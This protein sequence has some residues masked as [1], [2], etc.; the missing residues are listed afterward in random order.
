[1][2]S[3][4]TENGGKPQFLADRET[5]TLFGRGRL[6]GYTRHARIRRTGFEP[7]GEPVDCRRVSA[8]KHFDVAIGQVDRV[9]G[10]TQGFGRP[11]RAVAKK[12]ALDSPAYDKTPRLAHRLSP[13][14]ISNCRIR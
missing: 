10:E 2:V 9:T 11:A 6:G 3:G 13:A 8:G 1:M 12:N 5:H 4:L 7:G 14:G